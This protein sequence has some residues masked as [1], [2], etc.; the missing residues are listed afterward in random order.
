MRNVGAWARIVLSTVPLVGLFAVALAVLYRYD[1]R[2]DLTAERRYTLS[3]H[4]VRLLAG[5]D[6]DVELIAFLRRENPR[7]PYIRDLL[8]RVET[9][10][11]RVRWEEVDVNRSPARAHRYGVTSYGAV[12]VQRSGRYRVVPN[13]GEQNL[14]WAILQVTREEPKT[15][16]FVGGHGE[17]TPTD[18]DRLRGFSLAGTRVAEELY[19]VRELSLAQVEEV[20][21]DATVLVIAGPEGPLS[22]AERERLDAYLAAGGRVLILLDAL[23][24][25]DLGEY[26][27]GYGV[28]VRDETVVDPAARMLAGEF[29]T[30]RLE[31][32]G[33]HPITEGLAAPPVFS[34]ARP[35]EPGPVARAA[36][37]VALLRTGPESWATPDP[38]VLRRGSPQRVFGRDRPGPISVGVEARLAPPGAGSRPAGRLIVY[39]NSE[40]ATN[41]FLDREGNADLLL[42]TINWLA[43][44]E[45][46]IAPRTPRKQPGREQLLVLGQQG[47]RIFWLTVVVVPGVCLA[48]GLGQMLRQ[49]YAR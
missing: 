22:A 47:T 5:L 33:R 7:N 19:Q 23:E 2:I 37:V 14:M 31:A 11:P 28:I 35:V 36:E 18:R 29:V 8:R 1:L 9:A 43:D 21:P 49:R 38:D 26:L 24:E 20:P 4:A 42:N 27:R 12:V 46:L 34:R 6:T 13:P 41:F 16:Y 15:V 32:A 45:M 30:M 39:G 17:R 3:P 40:F 48:L 25:T 44:E 10:S